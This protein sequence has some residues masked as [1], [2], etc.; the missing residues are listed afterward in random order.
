MVESPVLRREASLV[1]TFYPYG[2]FVAEISI[3]VIDVSYIEVV[4]TVS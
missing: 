1:I 4:F 3:E 2:V